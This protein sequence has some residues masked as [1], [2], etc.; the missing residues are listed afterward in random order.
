[1]NKKGVSLIVSVVIY[2][3]LFVVFIFLLYS[4]VARPGSQAALDEQTN[5]KKIALI[6]DKA[7]PGMEAEI[8]TFKMHRLAEK[9]N[10]NGEIVRI[11]NENN[12]VN[13]KLTGGK[14]YDYYFFVDSRIVWNLDKNK[15]LLVLKF[16]E[17]EVKTRGE[18][19]G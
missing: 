10:F 8:D 11:D 4:A 19:S 13:V 14:G 17:P 2:I 15:R 12:K 18:E 9:N 1:M 5:A 3:V 7:K 16:F 6:I